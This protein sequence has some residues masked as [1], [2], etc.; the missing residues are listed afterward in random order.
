M[1]KKLVSPASA[2]VGGGTRGQS[3]TATRVR[4][5]LF[6]EGNVFESE[7]ELIM[8]YR[9]S[10]GSRSEITRVSLFYQPR[11][12]LFHILGDVEMLGSDLSLQL[13][14]MEVN[15]GWRFHVLPQ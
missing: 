1:V 13:S 5:L 4:E 2:A 6:R 8:H 10:L 11:R 7:R 12:F 9:F 15:G 3:P 14:A